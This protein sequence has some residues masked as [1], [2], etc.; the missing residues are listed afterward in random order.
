MVEGYTDVISMHQAGVENVV[1]SSGTSLTTEQIRLLNRFTK[2]ITVIYDGDSAGIHA[3]LRGIDMILRE[4]MNVRV[5]L[6]PEPE[7]PD[8]FARAHTAAEV[9]EYIRANEQDFLAF[10]AKLLLEARPGRP[11]PEGG[12]DR[13][14]GAVDRADSRS[15]PAVGLHQGVRADHGH[16]REHPDLGGG[17]Q[18]HGDDPATAR[19]TSSYARRRHCGMRSLRSPRWNS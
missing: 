3:S 12:A 6:L 11:D 2:N 17:A 1:S 16:R 5:V 15:D 9:Q 19:P 13:R 4:G 8:S 7:D 14:H 18:A 10:K